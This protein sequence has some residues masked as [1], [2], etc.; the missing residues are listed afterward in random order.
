MNIEYDWYENY[1]AENNTSDEVDTFAKSLDD[2]DML[3]N[4]IVNCICSAESHIRI[5]KQLIPHEAVK[6]RLMKINQE[7]IEYVLKSFMLT[8]TK[9]KNPKAYLLTSLYNAHD[10][11]HFMEDTELKN[12]D[13]ALFIPEKYHDDAFREMHYKN[14]AFIP[15]FDG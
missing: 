12:I 14:T 2:V 8:T 1:F 9:I 6:S 13:P 15:S 3:L 10:T 11:F 7:H 4:I 5:G